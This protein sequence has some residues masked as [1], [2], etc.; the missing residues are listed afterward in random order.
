MCTSQG[1][2]HSGVHPGAI[3]H[4]QIPQ[5]AAAHRADMGVRQAAPAIGPAAAGDSRLGIER[6]VRLQ[7]ND[8][9]P[10]RRAFFYP[11]EGS[12]SEL[13]LATDQRPITTVHTMSGSKG[14]P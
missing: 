8:G 4:R 5:Q 6:N 12:T 7:P 2:R 9:F 13:C 14:T 10:L 1:L 3:E 11:G